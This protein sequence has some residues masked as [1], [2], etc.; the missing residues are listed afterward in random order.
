MS[1]KEQLS[2]DNK[3]YSKENGADFFRFEDKQTT[4]FRILTPLETF[5][6]HF[7][8]KGQKPSVC[9]GIK[10]GCPWHGQLDEEGR[11]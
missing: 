2:R 9:Y 7:F 1:L 3:E 8:G 11:R 4:K 5:A 10:E 6:Q